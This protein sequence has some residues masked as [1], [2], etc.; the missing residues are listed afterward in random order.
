VKVSEL[1]EFGLIDV[2]ADLVKR[3]PSKGE[4]WSNL[5]I[6]IGDDAAAWRCQSETQLGTI[7]ALVQNVHF[8]LDTISW[9]DLGWKSLAVNVSD[10]AAMGGVPRYALV[11]LALPEDTQ[12]GDMVSF[13]RG[14]LELAG[15]QGVAIAGG[16]ITR[17]PIVTVNVAVLGEEGPSGALLRRSGAKAGDCVAVTGR[18][19]GAAA[20]LRMAMEGLKVENG[21]ALERAFARPVPR[22][23][24]GLVLAEN[25]VR[26][27]ID[28]SDG[29]VSDLGHVCD[30][31]RLGARIS[32]D[33]VPLADGLRQNFARRAVEWALSGGED[34]ELLF[35]C[36]AR[37]V[38]TVRDSL[39]CEITVIGEMVADPE[40]RVIL[41]DGHGK[42]F[43]LSRSGWDHFAGEK[44]GA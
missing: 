40:A 28:L 33:S 4:A 29:L 6:G 43:R 16:N 20:G 36:P 25:G 44:H 37:T 18:L 7:D 1:G 15:A 14:M 10:I 13:Y 22:V 3:D 23:R 41:L 30:A 38:E 39:D 11:S 24:E 8:K 32:V 21:T 2:L 9:E 17:S 27:A 35:T 31:S 26:T 12:V 34:Y 42:E 19:G 5:T